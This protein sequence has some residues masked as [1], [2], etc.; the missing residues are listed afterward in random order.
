M[1]IAVLV[2]KA[3]IRRLRGEAVGLVIDLIVKI[4]D[5]GSIRE[6]YEPNSEREMYSWNEAIKLLI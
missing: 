6:L 2:A 1:S 4:I 5:S 3:E